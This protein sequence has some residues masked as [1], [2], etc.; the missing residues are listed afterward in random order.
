MAAVTDAVEDGGEQDG[1]G[2]GASAEVAAAGEVDRDGEDRRDR[3]TR[4]SRALNPRLAGPRLR[5][6]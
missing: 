5:S 4:L 2:G 6:S 3:D 1:L